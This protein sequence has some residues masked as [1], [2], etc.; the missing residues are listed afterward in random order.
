M[1]LKKASWYSISSRNFSYK[2]FNSL[3][4][5]NKK[6]VKKIG[7]FRELLAAKL[8]GSSENT[9]RCQNWVNIISPFMNFVTIFADF[10]QENWKRFLG[11]EWFSQMSD[12]HG[13]IANSLVKIIIKLVNKSFHFP[14]K[15]F[16]TNIINNFNAPH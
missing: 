14:Q 5:Y 10:T 7:E 12:R 2:C 13:R 9:T 15:L 1:Q 4:N 11:W 16:P 8:L 3:Q 6:N